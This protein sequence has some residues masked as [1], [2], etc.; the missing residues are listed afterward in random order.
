MNARTEL[1]KRRRRD[2]E[3]K[4]H[5]LAR[6]ATVHERGE[7]DRERKGTSSYVHLGREEREIS[8]SLSHLFFT[9]KNTVVTTV[10]AVVYNL[11]L[12]YLTE[13]INKS[14]LDV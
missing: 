14:I 11:F 2:G 3:G 5:F 12:L 1:K 6:G 10:V 8:F 13:N 4:V 7:R 9:N